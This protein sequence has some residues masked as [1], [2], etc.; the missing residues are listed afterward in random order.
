MLELGEIAFAN[1]TS[2]ESDLAISD[3]SRPAL[4]K[5]AALLQVSEALL[6]ESLVS[7]KVVSGGGRGS[8]YLVPLTAQQAQDS[9]DSLAKACFSSLFAWLI[10]KVNL[11]MEEE[12]GVRLD[13]AEGADGSF[14]GLLDVFGF[15][16]FELNSF[17]Q[18]CI[19]FANEKLQQ[20]FLV[21]VFSGEEKNYKE[22]GAPPPAPHLPAPPPPR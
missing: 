5:A 8:A 9:R 14:V 1:A 13:E 7:R 17:E 16:N 21:T 12:A 15:E 22:E 3:G 11:T 10:S 20:F 19:N 4:A 18:L 2:S 6:E